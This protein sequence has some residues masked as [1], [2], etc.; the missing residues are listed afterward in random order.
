VNGCRGRGEAGV[1]AE[2]LAQPCQPAGT[3]ALHRPDRDAQRRRDLGLGQVV[4][5]AE[6]DDRALAVRQR[7]ERWQEHASDLHRGTVGLR[8]PVKFSV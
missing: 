3:G 6:H 1:V 7:G 2:E 4:E 8:E 5:V